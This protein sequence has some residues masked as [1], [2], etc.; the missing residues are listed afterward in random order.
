[1][2][3]TAAQDVETQRRGMVLIGFNVGPHR[4]VDRKVAWNVHK[5]RRILPIV[6]RRCRQ[7]KRD[8]ILVMKQGS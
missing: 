5:I 3:M 7:I 2:V 6:P 8:R 4:R 1:M